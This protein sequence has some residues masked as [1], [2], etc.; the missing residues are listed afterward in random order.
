MALLPALLVH[1]HPARSQSFPVRDALNHLQAA[2]AAHNQRVLRQDVLETMAEDQKRIQGRI[3]ELK[4]A[5]KS[6]DSQRRAIA[7][8]LPG[9]DPGHPAMAKV[10]TGPRGLFWGYEQ[11]LE[12]NWQKA[13][14][15]GVTQQDR[16]LIEYLLDAC[17][18]VHGERYCRHRERIRQFI[19]QA[20]FSNRRR[21]AAHLVSG[22]LA[23][24]LARP[25]NWE[26]Y[27]LPGDP[28]RPEARR[29]RCRL[30]GRFGSQ[31]PL[32]KQSKQVQ[33]WSKRVTA[34]ATYMNKECPPWRP[35]LRGGPAWL[36][37][38]WFASP[39]RIREA[40]QEME[41][42]KA[43]EARFE[44]GASR[45]QEITDTQLNHAREIQEELPFGDEAFLLA[46]QIDIIEACVEGNQPFETA[47]LLDPFRESGTLR[48]PICAGG[49]Q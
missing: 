29:F 28:G 21:S 39:E 26:A 33:G 14:E 35:P 13:R 25:K 41:Q 24:H 5:Q 46:L 22:A 6:A 11:Q 17:I 19:T 16:E 12:K 36:E 23:R 27:G 10:L 31:E 8:A 15:E 47:F 48:P 49:S 7:K 1:P 9:L 40:R 3:D 42:A 38:T 2:A 44:S 4:R 32:E 34:Y 20:R 43:L 18:A 37:E 45:L 30:A